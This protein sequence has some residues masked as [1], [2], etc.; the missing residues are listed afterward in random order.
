MRYFLNRRPKGFRHTFLYVDERKS[1]LRDVERRAR[2]RLENEQNNVS[3][4]VSG[5]YKVNFRKARKSY[6]GLSFVAVW[7]SLAIILL[8]L[9]ALCYLFI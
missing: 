1:L 9:V 4:K 6:A 7:L 5:D 8:L 3:D 2:Q